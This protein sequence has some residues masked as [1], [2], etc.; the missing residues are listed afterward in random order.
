[1][2]A[3]FEARRRADGVRVAVKT[4]LVHDQAEYRARF[5]R[6]AEL[7]ANLDHPNVVRVFGSGESDGIPYLVMEYL[8]GRDLRDCDEAADPR[9]VLLQVAEALEALHSRGVVHRDLKPANVIVTPE[10]RA[11][12]LD[13]GLA[14]RSGTTR[15][16][17]TGE[18]L[19]T[20]A[21]LSPELVRGEE[22][23]SPCDWFA[24]GVLAFRLLE[25]GLPF[26]PTEIYNTHQGL[27]LPR[28]Q[29]EVLPR[30]SPWAA[31]IDALLVDDPEERPANLGEVRMILG[32]DLQGEG[33]KPRPEPPPEVTAGKPVPPSLRAPWLVAGLTCLAALALVLAPRTAPGPAVR[34]PRTP[35]P[36]PVVAR[37]PGYHPG[38]PLPGS[39]RPPDPGPAPGPSP[40][41]GP[42]PGIPAPTFPVIVLR[43]DAPAPPP[44]PLPEPTLEETEDPEAGTA[45]SEGAPERRPS[46]LTLAPGPTLGSPILRAGFP[47]VGAAVL[48][49]ATAL[50]SA[51]HDPRL[52]ALPGFAPMPRDLGE[53]VA[54]GVDLSWNDLRY[55]PS[56]GPVPL[57]LWVL[58]LASG[59]IPVLIPRGTAF[60]HSGP[61]PLPMAMSLDGRWMAAWL[62]GPERV[63]LLP[64][65]RGG[66][67]RILAVER[68][69]DVSAM[70]FSP[71]GDRLAVASRGRLEVFRTLDGG[72][73]REIDLPGEWTS[74]MAFAPDGSRLYLA[75]C[76]EAPDAS[77]VP[78]A[79][80]L[81]APASLEPMPGWPGDPGC[82]HALAVSGDGTRVAASDGSFVRVRRLG[83]SRSDAELEPGPKDL[84]ALGFGPRDE[85]LIGSS[86]SGL[87]AWSVATGRRAGP[88]PEHSGRILSMVFSG[89]G[90]RLVVV[91]GGRLV[92]WDLAGPSVLASDDD[93]AGSI[94]RGA[95]YAADEDELWTLRHRGRPEE[96]YLPGSLHLDR[97]PARRARP[98]PL[99]FA[100]NDPR[101]LDAGLYT[102]VSRDGRVLA[103][104]SGQD[105]SV[106]VRV[107][108]G[109]G[110]RRE[111]RR[112][113][114][115]PSAWAL[116][117]D[118]SL[119]ATGKAE[120]LDGIVLD[121]LKGDAPPR[122][123]EV[124]R[125]ARDLLALSEDGGRLAVASPEGI[126]RVLST[127]D[128][129]LLASVYVDAPIGVLALSPD[130]RVVA[131]ASGTELRVAEVRDG[132][133]A[134]RHSTADRFQASPIDAVVLSPRGR[135]LVTAHVDGTMRVFGYQPAR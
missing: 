128:G 41:P 91:G 39:G 15:I 78:L 115:P 55:A 12:L 46:R 86:A 93:G 4:V 7:L 127:G 72:R 31:L 131:T 29:F 108:G 17:R 45:R 134:V 9:P 35:D 120:A 2:G 52:F 88:V 98:S 56:R 14:R 85:L 66:A 87:V 94:L 96:P 3:V 112:Q 53:D 63:L 79:I 124:P 114:R 60:P 24:W 43:V 34:P 110:V 51:G 100:A 71:G 113:P 119:L 104:Q 20:F 77:R 135:R 54:L 1:M 58:P 95:G 103:T 90:T 82:L 21:Y 6:E 132:V 133:V 109:E 130:G 65:V 101:F 123:L 47:W 38:S 5:R 59:G 102:A 44:L 92:H 10:G 125:G 62:A 105:G 89:D 116:A 22:G 126:V 117:G 75:P 83:A 30:N 18:V 8:E 69:E 118:G 73:S 27:P 13:F 68:P 81:D 61:D 11:V 23:G 122:T 37:P 16:T 70:V 57:A 106:R 76:D 49:D 121:A 36:V 97:I 26:L 33:G 19:G 84:V 42:A 107:A 80:S 48:P 111:V 99:E 28:P 129:K 40:P 64:T 74:A 32:L 67:P 25:G 50:L